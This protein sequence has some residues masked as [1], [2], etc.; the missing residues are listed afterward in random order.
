MKLGNACEW[1]ALHHLWNVDSWKCQMTNNS[2]LVSAFESPL[3]IIKW[4]SIVIHGICIFIMLIKNALRNLL[5]IKVD[6]VVLGHK[7]W[8]II[9]SSREQTGNRYTSRNI[10]LRSFHRE[11]KWT[12]P[13]L[14][15]LA[16]LTKKTP[17]ALRSVLHQVII[18]IRHLS[19]WRWWWQC[20]WWW[21]G[22]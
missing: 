18:F 22:W 20:W 13:M 10:H 2:C 8:K 17:R 4:K 15:I 9:P 6:Y 5:W 12:L 19:R 11:A 1:N 3:T 16:P 21:G 14:L 7:N